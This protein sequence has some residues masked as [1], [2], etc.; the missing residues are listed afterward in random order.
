MAYAIPAGFDVKDA[1][2][3][4]T[5]GRGRWRVHFAVFCG[6][7]SNADAGPPRVGRRFG[8]T[9]ANGTTTLFTWKIR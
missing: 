8:T 5:S 4:P 9:I 3:R 6:S 2:D 7:F 1:Y